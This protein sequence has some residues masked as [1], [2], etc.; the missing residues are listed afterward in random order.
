MNQLDADIELLRKEN[1]RFQSVLDGR[2]VQ[3]KSTVDGPNAEAAQVAAA[4]AA[5][6]AAAASSATSPS[7]P[8]PDE[9][10]IGLHFSVQQQITTSEDATVC[11]DDSIKETDGS[12]TQPE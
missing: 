7:S 2:V 4:V 10:T 12:A 1:D 3:R 9:E 5:A 6:A 8:N 11:L